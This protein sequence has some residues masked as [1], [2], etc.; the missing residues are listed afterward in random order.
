MTYCVG[1]MLRQGLIMVADTRTNAGI[2]NISTYRK[3]HV[4][5]DAKDSFIVAASAGNLSVTQLVLGML[6]E[7]L[8]SRNPDEAPRKVEHM[9]SM[10]QAAQ[11]VGEAVMAA[12]AQLKPALQAAGVS[13]GISLLLGGRIGGGPLKLFLIYDAGNF[14][15]C[16]PDSPFFQIGACQYGKPILDRAMNYDSTI[17]EAVKV[18]LLSFDSTIRSDKSVGLP[19]DV[20][21]FRNDPKLPII[22][23]RIEPDDAYMRNLSNR[24]SMLLNESRAAIPDPP[25]LSEDG[26]SVVELKSAG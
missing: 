20:M 21:V 4:L 5:A 10:F 9:P 18:A 8:P 14:I 2:D 15:E 17:D 26:D 13:S 23:R 11:L 3:L 16:Q 25:F 7:G 6:A 22:K 12:G 1:I 24:W 19:F